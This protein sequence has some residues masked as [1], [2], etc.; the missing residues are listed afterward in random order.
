MRKI[1]TP[2]KIWVYIIFIFIG[3]QSIVSFFGKKIGSQS[4][5]L[6]N[7]EIYESIN[8][9][10]QP[11]STIELKKIAVIGS[12][13]VSYGIGVRGQNTIS[14]STKTNNLIK[15]TKIWKIG[16]PY[17]EFV[18]KDKLLKILKEIHPDLICIQSELVAVDIFKKDE[19]NYLLSNLTDYSYHNKLRIY[20]ILNYLN[21]Y[22][23]KYNKFN[24]KSDVFSKSYDTINYTPAIRTAKKISD[25]E[26]AFNDLKELRNAGI[27]VV[28]LDL[29]RPKKVEDEIYT[30]E[31]S[32][33]LKGILNLYKRKFDMDYWPYTGQPL[34]YKDFK[35]GGHMNEKG[36]RIYTNW[37]KEKIIKEIK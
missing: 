23:K 6:P 22:K 25:I 17:V 15:L 35:D 1:E 4:L 29:P 34:Y 36:R 13:L 37:L 3:I 30:K 2:L 20:S 21:I 14:L 33:E 10:K 18:K 19:F 9:L 8:D 28:I 32:T 7:N 11:D 16:N 26:F 27:K 12:S 5:I 24:L 31:F